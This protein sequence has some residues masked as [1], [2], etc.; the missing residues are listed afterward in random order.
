VTDHAVAVQSSLQPQREPVAP[1]TAKACNSLIAK[2]A[3]S[4]GNPALLIR[5]LPHFQWVSSGLRIA[6]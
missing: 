5:E 1:R 6:L 2:F 4:R 3:N